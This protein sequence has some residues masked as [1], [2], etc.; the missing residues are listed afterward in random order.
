MDKLK[1][2]KILLKK[3]NKDVFGHIDRKIEAYLK[4]LQKI[5]Q[6]G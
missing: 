1:A 6:K 2:I 5:D 3:W 4:E